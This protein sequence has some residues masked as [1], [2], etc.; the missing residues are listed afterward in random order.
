VIFG[1]EH[2]S[3]MDINKYSIVPGLNISYRQGTVEIDKY[4]N[5]GPYNA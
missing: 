4:S 2:S 3:K 5:N 1:Y